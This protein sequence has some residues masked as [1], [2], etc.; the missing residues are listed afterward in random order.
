MNRGRQPGQGLDPAM[1]LGLLR[2][3]VEELNE[4]RIGGLS[5][6]EQL[7]SALHDLRVHQEEL[8]TQ[9]ESLIQLQEEIE[10]SRQRY[11]H[12]FEYAPVGYLSL[13]SNCVVRELNLTGADL[14]GLQRGMV[15]GKPFTLYLDRRTRDLLARHLRQVMRAEKATLE[16]EF[17][18]RDGRS[19]VLEFESAPVFD[20]DGNVLHCRSAFHDISYRREVEEKLNLAAKVIENAHEGV[21]VTDPEGRIV[22]VNPCF[23]RTTGYAEVEVLGKSPSLLQSGQH[24]KDFY[25]EMWRTIAADG[26]WQG[27]I[28]NRRKGG[29]IY[30]EWL[31]ITAIREAGGAI[32]HY[33]G[34]FSDLSTHEDVRRRLHYLA[35]Y[36]SLTGLP[37]RHLFFD[38]LR[39]AISQAGRSGC[40]VAL[41]F[42]DLDR[43]KLI[44]DTL[45][46]DIGDE[47]LR[48]VAVRLRSCV[49]E[50]D[51]IARMGGDEFTLVLPEV[52]AVAGSA[53][54]ARK[55]LS[56]LA[57]PFE[58]EGAR[59]YIYGSIGISHYPDDGDS[60]ETLL[61]HADTAMYR[62]KEMGRNT[63]EI[64]CNEH[65]ERAQHRLELENDLRAALERDEFEVHYQ[66]Q[67]PIGGDTPVAVE[68]LVRWNHPVHGL[69]APDRFISVAEE[70]GLIIA[71]GHRVMEIACRQV[72]AWR[73]AG[74][75]GL[76]VAVNLSAHQFMHVHLR[77]EVEAVLND[78]ALPPEALE[79]EVTESSAMPNL[80]YSART[81]NELRG[82]GITFALDD[83]G[84]GFSSLNYLKR[85]PF[86][87]L[88]IDRSFVTDIPHD[89][90]DSAIAEAIIS[91]AG[92]LG[93]DVVA[94]G[95]ENAAQL[96]FFRER[97]CQLYQGYFYSRTLPAA[98]MAALLNLSE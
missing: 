81:L 7:E 91:M 41:M 83:F 55:I 94:E 73:A 60:A 64:F 48:Q 17:T 24:D 53:T 44:N 84:T 88:K 46:H 43:F 47:L 76:R 74:C 97:G 10:F 31:N 39:Q 61:K 40:S 11:L 80:E 36:D 42:L 87:S 45:G 96:A 86:Q 28:W 38:R 33:V 95:V 25:T 35:Y 65:N 52:E 1:Q 58:L 5:K 70:T 67:V 26:Y 30:P 56:A 69:V 9:N 34:I 27:E 22:S 3:Q 71:I 21:V 37:N 15:I 79:L 16:V 92:S 50:V 23:E 66:P 62:A 93:L 29:D 77:D 89:G 82:L 72:Q 78:T 6:E 14:L 18:R 19:L 13:D 63:F 8:R 85:L 68:A 51:T 90:S 20:A 98:E 2:R 4:G 59:Y 49:R 54:V 12:L 75:T 57:E 32:S